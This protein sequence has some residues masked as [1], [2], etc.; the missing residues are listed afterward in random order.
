MPITSG[1]RIAYIGLIEAGKKSVTSAGMAYVAE[2][3]R[4][5]NKWRTNCIHCSQLFKQIRSQ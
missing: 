2:V 1:E 4:A 3:L 5:D